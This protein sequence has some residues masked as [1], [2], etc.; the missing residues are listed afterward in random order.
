MK[1]LFVLLM[2]FSMQMAAQ[3]VFVPLES[4]VYNFLDRMDAK[5]IIR[6]NNEVKPYS[7][8]DIAGY[9]ST[10]IE[11]EN[12][13]NGVEKEEIAWYKKEYFY[14][15]SLDASIDRWRV[16]GYEDSL[17]LFRVTPL[18]SYG[19]NGVGAANG[20]H[21]HIGINVYGTYSDMFGASLDFRDTGEF[22]DNVDKRKTFTPERGYVFVN[23][24]NGKEY[25]DVRGSINYNWSWGTIAFMKDYLNWGF[26]KFGKAILS[27][28]A[29]S[30][31]LVRLDAK[32]FPWLRFYY[33]HGWLN[34]QVI[35]SSRYY[36][37]NSN[38]QL[39]EK[40]YRF[41]PKYITANML[42]V[43]PWQWLDVSIGNS[44]VYAGEVR[45]EMLIPFMFYKYL[46]RDVGKGSIEDG[47]GQMYFDF[48]FRY[49]KN[50]NLYTT[51]FIEM[52]EIRNVLK[53]DFHNTWFGF[54][55]GSGYYSLFIDNLDLFVEYTRI[56][57][58]VYEHRD[59]AI[60]YKHLN[61]ELGH[62]IGQNADQF[63]IQI[64]YKPIRGL[65]LSGYFEHLRKGGLTD[66]YEAYKN[67][68]KES[69]LYGPLRKDVKLGLDVE[70]EIIHG[71][72][73]RGYYQFSN[74][75]DEDAKRTP[76]FQLGRKHSFGIAVGYG[77]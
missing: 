29:A 17:F 44:H 26:G 77:L 6:I 15:L 2:F 34:S 7:R 9:L 67:K 39:I 4:P 49:F 65:S 64:D 72:F 23:A 74:I 66:I 11:N 31:P 48:Q 61:Y 33:M 38:S 20:Y 10:I 71:L 59:R 18:A 55:I 12:L 32:P 76:A 53:N 60:D 62:W 43:S 8:I 69:F 47:N 16:Y 56:N 35:D 51:L 41:V 50:F 40:R 45:P 3:V 27:D 19:I 70:Y 46:D 52:L 1:F 73:A 30:F 63:R 57:P 14:E 37:A 42:T 75:S 68:E 22:G 5:R 13:L 28:N 21:R 54:T 25:S 58:W 36:I 24:P